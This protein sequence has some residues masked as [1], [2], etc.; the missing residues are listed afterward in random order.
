MIDEATEPKVED[1]ARIYLQDRIIDCLLDTDEPLKVSQILS[2]L[3]HDGTFTSRLLREVMESDPRFRA[4]DR[5]WTLAPISGDAR[6]PLEAL[7]EQVLGQI[8]RPLEAAHIALL[9]ADPLDRPAEVLAPMVQQVVAGRGKYFAAGSRWGL[10][11]WLLDV[12]D[13]DEEEIL[14]RNFF[15]DE[16]VVTRFRN[17]L[18]SFP[19]EKEDLTG[20]AV[21]FLQQAGRPVPGK[22]LQYFAWRAARRA[23]RSDA[24]FAALYA[25]QDAVL[26]SSG[27]WCSVEV[28]SEFGRVL[29]ELS[30]QLAEQELPAEEESAARPVSFD[31]TENEINQVAAILGDKRSHRISELIEA[32]FELSPGE[33]DYQA[34]FGSL[35][36]AMGADER[37]AWV[38]GERWRLAGTLPRTFTKI[39]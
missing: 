19:W 14:F 10:S 26:L 11:A 17:T 7:I 15:T 5:R 36:G 29:E 4:V 28:V 24:F 6:R 37:F 38:G 1:L 12:D 18:G 33:R 34:A 21:R 20:S 27:D 30:A 8:G 39:P 22:V 32:V 16:E 31:I 23:F 35:W 3:H 9:L 25:H 2:R 13:Q